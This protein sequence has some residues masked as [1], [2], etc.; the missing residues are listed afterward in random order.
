MSYIFTGMSIFG[1]SAYLIYEIVKRRANRII[2]KQE[3]ES[4]FRVLE[5][6]ILFMV[7]FFT[8]SVP[9]FIIAAFSTLFGKQEYIVADKKNTKK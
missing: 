4:I 3:N 9:T 7:I 2:Y 5:Y 6:I 1:T 8:M